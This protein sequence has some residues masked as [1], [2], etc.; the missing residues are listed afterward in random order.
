MRQPWQGEYVTWF[1]DSDWICRF[2]N[3]EVDTGGRDSSNFRVT[4]DYP[5]DYDLMRQV[6]ELCA[7]EYPGTYVPTDKIISALFE[8][9]PDWIYD[10]TRWPYTR[11]DVVIDRGYS[12]N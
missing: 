11:G 8:I 5:E 3:L 2:Q 1:F 7:K 6:A 9:D 4:L 10:E 12:H